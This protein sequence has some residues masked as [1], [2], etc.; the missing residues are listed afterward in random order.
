[1]FL[2]NKRSRIVFLFSIF[3]CLLFTAGALA[4]ERAVIIGFHQRPGPAEQALIHSAG[5]AAHRAFH[6]IPAM[7]AKVPEQAIEGLRRNPHVAYVEDDA[8]VSLIEP[9]AG[10]I[11][12]EN[13]WGVSHIGSETVHGNGFLGT[14]ARVAVIDTGIDYTHPDLDGNYFGGY[15]FVFNDADPFDDSYNSHG[16][17]VAGTIAA[18]L[19]WSGAGVVGVAPE[20]FLYAVKVL[21]GGGFGTL[22]LLI[23]GIEWAVENSMDVANMSLGVESHSQSLQDACDAADQAGV[24]LVAAAGN[25]IN[26]S[27]GPVLYP[28]AYGS[29]IAVTATDMNDLQAW[30]S[31]QGP[32]VELAAPGVLIQSTVSTVSSLFDCR[33]HPCYGDLSGTSQASPHV[34]GVAALVLSTGFDEDLNGDGSVNNKDV[35]RHLQDTAQDLGD[36]GVDDIYGYGLVSAAGATGETPPSEIHLAVTKTKGSPAN[37]AET[38]FLAGAK[39]EI[40]IVNDSLSKID[41]EVYEAGALV[42]DLSQTFRFRN[43]DLS[44]VTFKLNAKNGAY[45]VVFVPRGKKGTFAD[46]EIHEI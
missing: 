14:G 42:K 33:L 22:G 4:A 13:A 28:A 20:A 3:L 40:T 19:N 9:L 15:D 36:P 21:D 46:V 17:H 25:Y 38:V 41:V 27:H 23:A 2:I 32:E 16:T 1:M 8:V 7:A 31:S 44:E 18:E 11:E 26:G 39:F 29:V 30:F 45:D 37:S 24:L 6:L 34:A 5:G 35:R 10:S 12:Y 43:K